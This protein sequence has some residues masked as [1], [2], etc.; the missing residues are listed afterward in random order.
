MSLVATILVAIVALLHVYFFILE[1]FLWTK[2]YG[3]RVFRLSEEAAR[4]TASL[5]ANQ[6]VYNGFVA[7]GLFR[8]LVR[9]Q[10]GFQF[11]VF[12]LIFVIIAGIVGGMTVNRKI[13]FVQAVPGLIALVA[14]LLS[15]G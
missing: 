13:I 14:V 15:R 1:T 5:A 11:A 3:R 10:A 6:G 8:A 12:F 7:A 4:Q 2:R 9:D